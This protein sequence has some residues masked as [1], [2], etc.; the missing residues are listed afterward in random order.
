VEAAAKQGELEAMYKR[1]LETQRE[2]GEA[3]ESKFEVFVGFAEDLD[4]DMEQFMND[5]NDPET[6][7]RITADKE[8]GLQLGVRGTPTLFINEQM[9]Q[10]ESLDQLRAEFDAAL[11][12]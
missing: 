1:M 7:A 6:A 12:A 4:L 8:A 9:V 5:F 10:L 11:A 2:W 3:R